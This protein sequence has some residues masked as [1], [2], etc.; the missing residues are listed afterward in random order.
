MKKMERKDIRERI[1]QMMVGIKHEVTVEDLGGYL[2]VSAS[3]E[4]SITTD[5]MREALMEISPAIRVGNLERT[6]S[7]YCQENA[8]GVMVAQWMEHRAAHHGIPDFYPTL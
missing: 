8:L 7:D 1:E 4:D 5:Q 6:Y 3:Y 2:L